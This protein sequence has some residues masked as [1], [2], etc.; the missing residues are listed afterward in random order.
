MNGIDILKEVEKLVGLE[1]QSIRPG[2][3]ITIVNVDIE[4]NSLSL[5]TRNGEIKSRP[6][7]ELV[8]IWNEMLNNKVA[9]VEGVLHGSGTSRNQPETILANLPFVEWLKI[10]NKK[11]ITIVE[12]C[13]HAYGTKKQ[14]DPIEADRLISQL[15]SNA[16][17]TKARVAVVS[18]D[19]SSEITRV[20]NS[21]IGNTE[22]V[23]QGTYVLETPRVDFVFMQQSD[24]GIQEGSYVIVEAATKCDLPKVNVGKEQF[25]CLCTEYLKL[26][27]KAE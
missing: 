10:N 20:S 18:S 6:L 25:Y 11:H 7:A 17:E 2:A 3:E 14:M 16:K 5:R 1:L 27:I 12:K 22:A 19:V 13:S 26:L 21:I 23:K 4:R 8:I 15:E 9:H 24:V